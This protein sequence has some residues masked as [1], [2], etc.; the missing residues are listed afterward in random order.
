VVVVGAGVLG[1]A[2]AFH[3]AGLGRDVLQLE[4]GPLASE[5]SSQGAGLLCSIR[6]KRSSA[7]IVR[8]STE[9]YLR[10]SDETGYDIDLHP[11]GGIRV[12][13]TRAWLEEIRIDAE[14]GRSIGV[15]TV[16]LTPRELADRVPGFDVT[17]AVGGLF[18]PLEGYITATKEAAIGLAR[19][20]VRRGGRLRT[21]EEV[22]AVHPRSGGGFEVIAASG[23]VRAE[24]VVLATNAALWPLLRRLGIPLAA[25]PVHHQCAVYDTPLAIEP[26][27]PTVRIAER[28]LY[29]RREVG[30]LLVGGV[31]DEPGS[32]A[33]TAPDGAFDLASVSPDRA[34]LEA[35]RARATAFVPDLASA[36]VIRE[37]RG[38][39]VVAPDLEPMLGEILP[40]LFVVTADLRGIQSG[41]GLGLM[42]AQLIATGQSEW[43][44]RP[45]RPDRFGDLAADPERVRQAAINGIRPRWRAAPVPRIG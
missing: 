33:V 44:P 32:P 37:Q 4:R 34:G 38:L 28:D 18:T 15:E 19:G 24:T 35:M 12:A 21:Y 8:Y 11:T 27:L 23:T 7:E 42:L 22:T 29:I 30:G 39:A 2:T 17:G 10:F 5:T 36:S 6:P 13:L 20:A 3:L 45:F 25:Y 40:R 41:P 26:A 14:T 16:E 31:G 9:F 43:D 1:S